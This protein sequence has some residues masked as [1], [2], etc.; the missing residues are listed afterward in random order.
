MADVFLSYNREDQAKAKLIAEALEA[1]GFEVWWDT[2]L[3]AGQTYDEVTER[4]LRDAW[5]VVV[6]WSSRSVR[7]KWVRAEATLGDRKSA[8][9]P[10]MIE[11]CDRPIMFELI[12]TADLTNWD[13][14]LTVKNWLD[15]VADV[16]EHVERKRNADTPSAATV[17]AATDAAMPAA[18]ETVEAAFWMSVQDGDDPGDFE[19]Y[20]E[21]YPKG[22]FAKLARKRL[23]ALTE[24]R[25]APAPL[26]PVPPPLAQAAAP[27]PPAPTKQEPPPL[28]LPSTLQPAAPSPRAPAPP[29]PARPVPSPQ[30]VSAPPRR[31]ASQPAK[32]NP[33]FIGLGALAVVVGAFVLW[34]RSPEAP[35]PSQ[36]ANVA[37]EAAPTPAAPI[38][39]AP[40]PA[41]ATTYRD[42]DL[43][44]EMI[45]LAG[46]A[47]QMGSPESEPG[48][49]SWEGPQHE[50]NIAPFAIGVREV[51]MAEWTA[52]VAAS[53]CYAP[54]DAV[55]QSARPAARISWNDAQAYVRWLSAQG[56]RAYRLPSEAEWEFAARGG[57]ASAFW[58]GARYDSS[59][60]SRSQTSETGA[61]AANGFGL[62]DITGNVAEWVEDCYVNGFTAAPANGSAM[63]QGNCSQRVVRG[64]SWRDD[65]QSLRIAA[66]SRI[67]RTTR[68]GAIGFRVAASS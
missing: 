60:V 16:R 37:A 9:I 51:T 68:D 17:V 33:M 36:V 15:F 64:G 43:C 38:P 59:Q 4:Q 12:Q 20:L 32:V 1:E 56:G 30:S 40:Q 35:S 14:E 6:L 53:A 29:P 31:R 46:G 48:R 26:A 18:D 19:D 34:P 47:F 25:A 23:K 7:S 57:A 66:R 52:C 27:E 8:L 62:Y 24:E 28:P 49:R 61:H 22:H 2:V 63:L 58:W 39:P 10:V 44:P 41:A 67:S 5:A 13:G 65:P 54:P 21:R 3:R 50:V 11:P 55:A 42:C 45:R